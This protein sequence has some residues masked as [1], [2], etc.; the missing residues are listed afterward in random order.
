MANHAN[1][2][3]LRDYTAALK[4]EQDTKPI[5]GRT[6]EL[7]PLTA[8]RSKQY[9]RIAKAGDE[10]I[11]V[12]Y[13]QNTPLLTYKPDGTIIFANRCYG[14]AETTVLSRLVAY[15]NVVGGIAWVYCT[16]HN[17]TGDL[18]SGY[19]PIPL[20]TR[21]ILRGTYLHCPN[22]VFHTRTKINRKAANVVRKG[23]KDFYTYARG[24]LLLAGSAY[25]P[26]ST[27]ADLFGVRDIHTKAPKLYS[28]MVDRP[29]IHTLYPL[30]S[31]ELMYRAA[32]GCFSLADGTCGDHARS[33]N[34][35]SA[36]RAL[37][38]IIDK[39]V[40]MHHPEVFYE[41]PVI[42]GRRIA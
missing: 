12:Y 27:F 34:M 28:Y 21:F 22:P 26:I 32:M 29:E 36:E 9:L 38:E 6:P 3:R 20:N 7:K 33:G 35:R 2:P 30:M 25:I 13:P 31:S 17:P 24:L 5:R 8:D 41:E 19:L 11:V 10:S 42:D 40:F 15:T 4:H 39:A 16:F 14:V 1:V 37:R 18:V 23:V